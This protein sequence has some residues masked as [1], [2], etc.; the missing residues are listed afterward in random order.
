MDRYFLHLFGLRVTLDTQLPLTVSPRLQPFFS[1][2]HRQA[3]C[4]IRITLCDTLPPPEG[5]WVGPDC[6]LSRDSAMRIFHCYKPRGD[7]FAVTDMDAAGNVTIS[8]LPAYADYFSGSAGIFNCIGLEHMLLRQNGLL[9]HASLIDHA[10]H[11]I[12]FTGP[13]GIGKSTQAAL[14][15]THLGAAVLNGDRAALRKT[16]AGWTAYGSPYAGTSGIYK[17]ESAPLTALVILKQAEENRLRRLPLAQAF[18]RI[19]PELS[20]PRWEETF[21]ARAA[22]LCGALLADVPVYLLE[23]MPEKSAVEVLKKGLQL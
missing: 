16:E 10:G 8:A 4:S 14:W 17:N 19:W 1:Q 3:D 7:A 13:S 18:P 5:V 9:L 21:V 22:D 12:A 20:V 23:C 11:G 6:F 2:P 15:Q